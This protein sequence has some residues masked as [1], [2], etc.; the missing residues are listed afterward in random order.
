MASKRITHRVYIAKP[1]QSSYISHRV[2]ICMKK[3]SQTQGPAYKIDQSEA[4]YG[5]A[6][7]TPPDLHLAAGMVVLGY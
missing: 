3:E 5:Q 4:S 2:S 1:A 7:A 6:H